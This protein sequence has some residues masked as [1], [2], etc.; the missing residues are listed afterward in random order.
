M[1]IL[2]F[3]FVLFL[4]PAAMAA[5][6]PVE[7][8][9][10][11]ID[12]PAETRV[13][14]EFAIAVAVPGALELGLT[15]DGTTRYEGG[16]SVS[17]GPFSVEEP[18]RY[19]V[20][21]LAN[22]DLAYVP[23]GSCELA[24]QLPLCADR[25][26][27]TSV[28]ASR[29]TAEGKETCGYHG[30]GCL[31]WGGRVA[32]T[33]YEGECIESCTP[34]VARQCL[35]DGLYAIDA[36]GGKTRIEACENCRATP[37]PHCP[38]SGTYVH[39]CA[40]ET[41]L[42]KDMGCGKTETLLTCSPDERCM[43]DSTRVWCA[44]ACGSLSQ[45]GSRCVDLERSNTDCGACNTPCQ[46]GTVCIAGECRQDPS[47]VIACRE[48]ADC[49][50]GEVCIAPGDCQNS[51][52]AA[53]S[54]TETQELDPAEVKQLLRDLASMPG[55]QFGASGSASGA[56]DVKVVLRDS[57]F[58]FLVTNHLGTPLRDVSFSSSFAQL[59]A[60]SKELRVSGARYEVINEEPSLRFYI[61][62]LEEEYAF[63]VVLGKELDDSYVN[64]LSLGSVVFTEPDLATQYERG[65]EYLDVSVT[66]EFDGEKT[67]VTVGLTTDVPATEVRIPVQIP[68]CLAA[69]AA[70]LKL[71]GS[72]RIIVDDP[73]IVWRFDSVDESAAVLFSTPGDIDE[74][75]RQQLKALAYAHT[76]KEPINP[77]LALWLIPIVIISVFIVLEKFPT[78]KEHLSRGEFFSLAKSQGLKEKEIEEEWERYR[79]Q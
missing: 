76:F 44:S 78:M 74:E 55:G 62:L 75:C 72:Y 79:D 2:A 53:L 36:C 8:Y 3:L 12:A 66:S 52:C 59:A 30:E 11:T 70:D 77:M 51:R 60:S 20:E 13:G 14:Q 27:C 49:M 45:C 57:T 16:S 47:C 18:G 63:T 6:C 28:G 73:L 50:Q 1:R 37:E 33:C 31:H 7:L 40:G 39:L 38:C 34:D 32:C 17:F 5:P 41:G 10:L 29:C 61:P 42:R 67:D 58:H 4:L 64:F 69:H 23:I 43:T 68:K 46:R 71:Y 24:V 54:T 25:P 56:I 21:A 9:N 65:K 22:Y 48:N 26:V 19:T 35:A 15:F